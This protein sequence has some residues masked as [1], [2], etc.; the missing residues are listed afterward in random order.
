VPVVGNSFGR[1][2]QH[3]PIHQEVHPIREPVEPVL[4]EAGTSVE[5]EVDHATVIYPPSPGIEVGLH[6]IATE[7]LDVYL[8]LAVV[9]TV[10]V[11]CVHEE[12][13]DQPRP[14]GGLQRA[15]EA[16]VLNEFL[17]LSP[18]RN[19]RPGRQVA[20]PASRTGRRARF[21]ADGEHGSGG[22]HPEREVVGVEAGPVAV[23]AVGGTRPEILAEAVELVGENDP[24][25]RVVAGGQAGV[26]RPVSLRSCQGASA[27]PASRASGISAPSRPPSD[28]TP[29]AVRP[30][31]GGAQARTG[32]STS[33]DTRHCSVT[34]RNADRSDR[35]GRRR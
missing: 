16:A 26:V 31:S 34:R 32:R 15:P 30:G 2:V 1:G 35:G 6:E 21:E 10:L 27:G 19:W 23:E 28:A 12:R 29:T 11:G 3:P 7:Q 20:A 9:G 22:L 25:A 13:G 14:A 17:A 8:V 33:Q 24:P 5:T 18:A 4:V